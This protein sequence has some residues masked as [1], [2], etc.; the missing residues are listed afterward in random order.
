MKLII[1]S[2]LC[3][4]M[5]S[6]G[7]D[8]S[9]TEVFWVSG[10]KTT[11]DVGT[12]LSDCLLISK[13]E[14]LDQAEW[15]LFYSAIEGFNFEEGYLKKVEVEVTQKKDTVPDDASALEYTF[16][17]ELETVPDTR[18]ELNCDWILQSIGE[19]LINQDTVTPSL[20]FNF[21][22]MRISGNGGC[23]VFNGTIESIGLST[24]SLG[25]VLNTLRICEYQDLEDK[26]L[27]ILQE[28]TN[29]NVE[30]E[31]LTLHGEDKLPK[32]VYRKM[33][34][35]SHKTRIHDIWTVAR[36]GGYPLNRMVSLPRLEVNTTEMKIYGND[37]CN[38]YFG[39]LT[40]LTESEIAVGGIGS[41]RKMCDDM[42]VPNRFNEALTKIGSYRFDKQFLIFDDEDGKEILAFIKTD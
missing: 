25:K 35:T 11:C 16:I 36:I 24:L 3:F 23:N 12:G 39:T 32:L 22:D 19:E 29:F 30:N 4:V 27:N 42:E 15:E 6:C 33:A 1:Y 7:N 40:S 13:S 2:L 14:R 17:K 20:S 38:D 18:I 34:K 26:Y 41:T 10:F 37:G 31:T 28:C 8:K 9:T 5:L 21:E